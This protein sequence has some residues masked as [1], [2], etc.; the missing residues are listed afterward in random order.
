MNRPTGHEARKPYYSG[1]KKAHTVKTRVVVAPCGRI[2]AVGDS[3]P[4]G[5]AHDPPLSCGS[6]VLGQL[7]PGEAA[8]ADKG[9][10]GLRNYHTVAPAAVPFQAS[11]AAP[12]RRGRRRTTG[13]RRAT[14]SR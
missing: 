11:W 12:R 6:G 9:C 3:V 1:K 7:A 14:G 4:G 13:R 2:E 8:M 5:A 10:V